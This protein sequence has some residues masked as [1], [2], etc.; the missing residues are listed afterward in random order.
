MAKWNIKPTKFVEVVKTDKENLFVE[1]ATD[2]LEILSG[3]LPVD[4]GRY[5]ANHRVGYGEPDGSIIDST[6]EPV[7]DGLALKDVSIVYIQN[8][9]PYADRIENG[10]SQK[11]P[12]G[13][14]AKTADYLR[15]KYCR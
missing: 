9:L 15:E 2:A 12:D 5:R 7:I 6:E 4:T 10:W 13:V 3:F 8:N 11:A 1:M 14:Y